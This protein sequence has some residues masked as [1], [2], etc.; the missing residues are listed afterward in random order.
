ME[1]LADIHARY[2][3]AL[4]AQDL[5]TPGARR[6][7]LRVL[8]GTVICSTVLTLVVLGVGRGADS[9]RPEW[10]ALTIEPA[11]FGAGFLGAYVG[12]VHDVVRGFVRG[13]LTS[14]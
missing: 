1:T 4:D 8:V 6:T 10:W 13:T 2:G 5:L 12:H 11:L 9:S 14:E 3:E 7:S